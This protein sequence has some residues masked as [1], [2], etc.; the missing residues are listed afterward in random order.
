MGGNNFFCF[1]TQYTF[2]TLECFHFHTENA[3]AR[4]SA[5]FSLAT[6]LAWFKNRRLL[7]LKS[8]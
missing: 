8:L 1:M 5:L 7:K 2:L 3:Q 4:S 6:F